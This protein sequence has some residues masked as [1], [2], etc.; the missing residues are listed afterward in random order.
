MIS[1]NLSI[2]LLHQLFTNLT[3]SSLLSS[4]LALSFGS[5]ID[6]R[7]IIIIA[8]PIKAP[9]SYNFKWSFRNFWDDYQELVHK[10]A[11]LNFIKN[12]DKNSESNAEEKNSK[13]LKTD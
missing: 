10:H 1:I 5:I 9:C 12:F 4:L 13:K 8:N 2:Y 11:D 6:R 3:N 7:I